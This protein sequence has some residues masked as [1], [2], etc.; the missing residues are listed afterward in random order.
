MIAITLE[1][2]VLTKQE[3]QTFHKEIDKLLTLYQSDKLTAEAFEK[4]HSPKYEQ[5]QEKQHCY[6]Y[7]YLLSL[8]I[9]YM[10][11]SLSKHH[12]LLHFL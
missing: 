12:L 4:Y 7:E 5:L 3:I 11:L 2:L 9:V 6:L 1:I 10:T 8:I